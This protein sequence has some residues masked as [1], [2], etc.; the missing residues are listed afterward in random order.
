MVNVFDCHSHSLLSDGE[1]GPVELAR[2]A[3]EKGL[4]GLA[5]TDH[6][7]SV[8]VQG[9]VSSLAER[10]DEVR[11]NMDIDLLAGCE[12]THTPPSLIPAVASEASRLGAEI[13]LVH[14]ETLV[15]PVRAG[16]NLAAVQTPEVDVLA[17][18]GLADDRTI[19]LAATNDVALE[20]SARKGHSLANGHLVRVARETEVRLMINTDSHAPADLITDDQAREVIRGA[21]HPDPERVLVNN[22][23]IFLESRRGSE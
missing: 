16:T 20:I 23:R 2:R 14:G 9:I 22:E 18:P 6:V 11:E 10:I 19:E 4:E 5:I 17:H 7:D 12:I 8:T 13:I 1:L 21:G 3:E 15:E